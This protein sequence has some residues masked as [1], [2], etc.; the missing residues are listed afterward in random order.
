MYRGT[1]RYKGWCETLDAMKALN[2]LDD[3]IADYS[4]M[5]Y[6]DFIAERAGTDSV[7]LRKSRPETSGS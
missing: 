6:T 4:G 2:M 5:D 7:D 3:T 1:F